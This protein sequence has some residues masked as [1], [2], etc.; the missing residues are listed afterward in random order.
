M[1]ATGGCLCGAVRY[2]CDGEPVFSCLCHCRN[3][4]KYTGSAFETVLAYPSSQVAVS[5]TFS[6]YRDTGDSGKPVL[7]NFCPVCGS[8]IFAVVEVLPDLTLLLAGTLDDPAQFKPTM[9]VYCDSAQ[10]WTHDGVER[11]RHAKMPA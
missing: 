5:G 6:T 2:S 1:T 9:E 10:P 7:R 8:G 3:C 4:Q 11:T